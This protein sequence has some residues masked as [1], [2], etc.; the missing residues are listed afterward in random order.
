MKGSS[1]FGRYGLATLGIGIGIAG[2]LSGI[3]PECSR[4]EAGQ[5]IPSSIEARRPTPAFVETSLSIIQ[6]G[7]GL[8]SQSSSRSRPT[9]RR[10]R[11]PWRLTGNVGMEFIYDDNIFRFS[12]ENIGRFR[13]GEDR[14]R[15]KMKTYDDFIISPSITL[16]LRRRLIWGKDSN[17]WMKYMRYEYAT[18]P[19]KTNQ[20]LLL[21]AR[22]YAWGR[23]F[24]EVAFSYSPNGYIREMFDRPP[25][26]SRVTPMQFTPFTITRSS[27][28]FSYWK[29]INPSLLIRGDLQRVWRFY[30]REFI[31]NDNW[32]WAYS[33]IAFITLKNTWRIRAQYTYSDVD[34]RIGD[35]VGDTLDDPANVR[36]G[37]NSYDRDYYSLDFSYR[38][39]GG[40]LRVLRDAT[41][42]GRHMKFFFTSKLPPHIDAWHTGR[43]DRISV[44]VFSLDTRPLFG[45][46]T[47]EI[48]YR[49]TRR[50]STAAYTELGADSID[51]DKDYTNNRTWL[52]FTYRF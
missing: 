45:P 35:T 47:A 12:D 29:R 14:D 5:L 20:S 1:V 18:N 8:L 41:V 13:R 31:E 40:F 46:V 50:S 11:N 24:A 34:G 15:Y 38:P 19:I 28:R 36:G 7:S 23:D 52:G 4:A 43:L 27:L 9:Q 3:L 16:D 39:R 49:F 25:F 44:F 26:T 42:G 6:P 37:D 51:E 30:N 33:G 10:Q 2:L 22:Q 21:R 48:G 17:F 32:E